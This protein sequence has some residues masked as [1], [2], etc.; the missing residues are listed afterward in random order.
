MR[1]ATLFI[2]LLLFWCLLSGETIN[3]WNHDHP[4]NPQLL[5]AAVI[6]AVLVLVTSIRM[7]I[8]DD[9]GQPLRVLPLFTYLPW[10]AWQILRANIDIARVVWSPRLPIE[11]EFI[12]LKMELRSALGRAT[13][14]NSIT[15]T[16]GTVT[17]Q[18]DGDKLLVHALTHAAAEEL[19]GGEMERRLQSL[20]SEAKAAAP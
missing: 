2:L 5:I 20:D 19:R 7:G 4:I 3:P 1:I 9:E 18:L 16:P 8:V 10:L 11:P 6:S 12:E 15:L 13:Y 14:A 17:V